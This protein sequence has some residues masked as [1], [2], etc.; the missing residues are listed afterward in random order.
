MKKI[1]LVLF[2]VLMLVTMLIG[3]AISV[4]AETSDIIPV[5]EVSAIDRPYKTIWELG[6]DYEKIDAYFP[7]QIEIRYEGGKVY[8]EDF[9]ASSV[10]I[11]DSSIYNYVNL[12]LIDGYWT[13]ELSAAPCIIKSSPE[14]GQKMV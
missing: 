8:V 9:G 14:E 1:I 4:S 11:Y 2:S 13:A 10:K 12:E 5:P 3:A 7:Q 6:I